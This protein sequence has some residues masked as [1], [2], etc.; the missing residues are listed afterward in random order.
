MTKSVTS[1][2]VGIAVRDG[3]LALDD[4]VAR[5]VP[6][7]RHADS[8]TVTVRNLLS[9]DSGR[10][11]SISTDYGDLVA[12]PNR[13]RYAVQL[14]QQHPP[15][16]TWAYNNAAIQVLDRVLTKATGMRTADFAAKRLFKPL[17]MTHSQLTSDS[18][19]RSTNIFFGLQ[20][21]CLDLARFAQLYLEHGKV[22]RTRILSASYVRASVG[23]SSTELNAAY[24]YLWW[25]NRYG[26][27]RGATDEV[28]AAGQPLEPHEGRLVPDAP[29]S[30]FSAIGLRGQIAMVDRRSRTIVVRIGLGSVDPETAHNLRD[31]A[32]IVTWALN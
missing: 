30:L 25:L 27:L 26:A 24:G 10:Y 14:G 20:T 6:S 11:W 15:G 3:S 9:N 5:Y 31:A 28:D 22:G 16:S 1:A 21:T 19:G 2:L 32:R 29:A 13:T 7:W 23:G 4:R 8:R 12:A 18:S 17:G